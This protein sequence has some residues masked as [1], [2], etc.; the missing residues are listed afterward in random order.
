P[1]AEEAAHDFLWRIHRES[2]ARGEVVIFNRS[3]YEDVLVPKV[4]GLISGA[5]CLERYENINAFENLL[6][7]SGVHILKFFLHISRD[8]Q[9]ERLNKRLKDPSRHWKVK[10]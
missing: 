1:T 5:Q 10:E 8:E 3:H 2:P 4:Y 7:Q 6:T 9:L